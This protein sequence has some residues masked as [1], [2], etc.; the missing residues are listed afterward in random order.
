MGVVFFVWFFAFKA[1][2]VF[3]VDSNAAVQFI[4]IDYGVSKLTEILSVHY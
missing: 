2:K 1:M 4:F 3:I